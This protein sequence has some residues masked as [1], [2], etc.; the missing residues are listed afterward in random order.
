MS[1]VANI[2]STKLR[3]INVSGPTQDDNKRKEPA[4]HIK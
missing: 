1:K 4:L 2:D 3:L